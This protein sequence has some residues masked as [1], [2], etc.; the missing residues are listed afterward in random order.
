MLSKRSKDLADAL[1][2]DF[3]VGQIE[4]MQTIHSIRKGI[5]VFMRFLWQSKVGQSY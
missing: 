4:W 2:G 3:L 5:P 1:T